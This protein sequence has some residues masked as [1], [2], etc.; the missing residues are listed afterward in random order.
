[1]HV[2]IVDGVRVAQM[3]IGELMVQYAEEIHPEDP[4]PDE[5]T[6]GFLH[7]AVLEFFRVRDRTFH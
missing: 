4:T 2:G 1:M 3:Q 5:L 6:D 7:R